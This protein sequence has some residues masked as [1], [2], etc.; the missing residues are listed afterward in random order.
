MWMSDVR[1][2]LGRDNTRTLVAAASPLS[3]AMALAAGGALHLF[4]KRDQSGRRIFPGHE[5]QGDSI[6]A[7]LVLPMSGSTHESQTTQTHLVQH[8]VA[9]GHE[10]GWVEIVSMT[11][12]IL[13]RRQLGSGRVLKFRASG[14]G[15]LA[16]GGRRTPMEA[17]YLPSI[18]DLLMV[19]ADGIVAMAGKV[20]FESLIKNQSLLA[21]MRAQGLHGECTTQ[22]NQ[23]PVKRLLVKDQMITDMSVYKYANT[24]LDQMI[25]MSQSSNIIEGNL[26]SLGQITQLVSVGQNPIMRFNSPYNIHAQDLTELAENV[27]STVKSGFVRVATGL[28]WGKPDA[29][30]E[31]KKPKELEQRLSL[32]HAMKDA[33][34]QGKMIEVSL[35]GLYFA[36]M[37]NQNRVILVDCLSGIILHVWKGLHHVQIGW[38]L[39]RPENGLA[40]I[41]EDEK[42]AC[43]LV[44]YLPRRG[45]LEVWWPES[46][47]KLAEF[48]V[49]KNGKLLS[50][51]NGIL[52]PTNRSRHIRERDLVLLGEDG[53]ISEIIIP[54]RYLSDQ[55]KTRYSSFQQQHLLALL[56]EVP[57]SDD[58][59]AK[60]M[61]QV[62]SASSAVTQIS[63]LVDIFKADQI[64]LDFVKRILAE[65]DIQMKDRE[66]ESTILKNCYATLTNLVS[67]F[68]NI[69]ESLASRGENRIPSLTQDD[70]P[71]LHLIDITE[72]PEKLT[73][74]SPLNLDS[75]VSHWALS[76][77]VFDI[78]TESVEM[79]LGQRDASSNLLEGFMTVVHLQGERKVLETFQELGLSYQDLL[80]FVFQNVTN[81]SHANLLRLT[82]GIKP[83]LS[84]ALILSRGEGTKSS[85][86]YTF[87]RSLLLKEPMNMSVL[88]L[89]CQWHEFAYN[90]AAFRDLY[91][92]SD[93]IKRFVT[94]YLHLEQNLQAKV[95]GESSKENPANHTY[96]DAFQAGNGRVVEII[97]Q[98]FVQHGI[99]PKDLE[100]EKIR[101][102][103]SLAE[104]DFPK[105]V[106]SETLL[107]HLT[108]EYI[109]A[110]AKKRDQLRYLDY[111]FQCLKALLKLDGVDLNVPNMLWK[112]FLHKVGRDAV[113]VTEIRSPTRCLRDVGVGEEC[114][115]ELLQWLV[116]VLFLMIQNDQRDVHLS[117]PDEK[118][119][120]YDD[121]SDVPQAHLL[122]HA[123]SVVV[124]S[125]VIALQF[126]YV[127]VANLIWEFDLQFKPMALFSNQE[128]NLFFQ[129]EASTQL[130]VLISMGQ[131]ASLRHIRKKF[132]D[133]A[134]HR[135]VQTIH[136]LPTEDGQGEWD[137]SSYK[138]WMSQLALL[139]KM[140]FLQ[141][142]LKEYQILALYSNGHDSLGED[143]FSCF[144]DRESLAVKL[145]H[146]AL[147]RVTKFVY[148]SEDHNRRLAAVKPDLL[149]KLS[150]L[151]NE[152]MDI[153]TVTVED[154]KSLLITL[155]GLGLAEGMMQVIYDCLALV[156]M[157][158]K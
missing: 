132:L 44:I 123:H 10:S 78:E 51:F 90:N 28:F 49:A 71:G 69:N 34:K 128:S 130:G 131:N 32:N 7:L 26:Q 152:A 97:C 43:V 143:L 146:I 42:V 80:K 153:T 122:D 27:V 30:Q 121:I 118:P 84:I 6:S 100:S 33:M 124:D 109:H 117:K 135:S 40:S 89:A 58:T 36:V 2:D 57:L 157:F 66:E 64:E 70:F 52:D 60:V 99:G 38:T 95:L 19:Y 150:Q 31:D 61:E 62:K 119:Q 67:L 50:C 22:D 23:V 112:T 105:S 114:L 111:G 75:F 63:M 149:V 93:R 115:P 45:S 126:Q 91:V 73:H 88:V 77:D 18:S 17:V 68:E 72:A 39:A 14:D 3:E 134:C 82:M 46:K 85:V 56:S 158:M 127:F 133:T 16:R 110:W 140:W 59:C 145:I 96:A 74:T 106:Q 15:P 94:A 102:F 144:P 141:D 83:L 148:E 155:C 79:R 108:W 113:N 41:D 120:F 47:E 142:K 54:T 138:V 20:L 13:F 147:L 5:R 116:K 98:W 139:A 21:Q 4:A 1:E 25:H 9:V 137:M 53:S 11:G 101:D 107:S 65:I 151:Q 154:T 92:D 87:T 12:D 48:S 76:V 24:A 55:K 104:S 81:W 86:F 29:N 136:L 125:D 35:N 129:S 103:L 156:Q 8:V 37:D